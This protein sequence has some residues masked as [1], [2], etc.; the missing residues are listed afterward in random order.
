MTDKRL[1]TWKTLSFCRASVPSLRTEDDGETYAYVP[2]CAH[3][4]I[5]TDTEIPEIGDE[6]ILTDCCQENCPIWAGLE[7]PEVEDE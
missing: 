6:D 1:I 2:K 5:T 7:T 4:E 3:R